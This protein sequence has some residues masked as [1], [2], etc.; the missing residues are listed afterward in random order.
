LHKSSP[1]LFD[2]NSVEKQDVPLLERDETSSLNTFIKLSSMD[3][4][5]RACLME[6]VGRMKSNNIE[7]T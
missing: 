3:E 2:E 1:Y 6:E 4:E 7:Y 5:F